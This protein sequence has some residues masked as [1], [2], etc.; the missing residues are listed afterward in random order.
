MV[1]TMA[2]LALHTIS[3]V[4][5]QLRKWIDQVQ[6]GLQSAFCAISVNRYPDLAKPPSDST[7]IVTLINQQVSLGSRTHNCERLRMRTEDP[8]I[9]IILELYLHPLTDQAQVH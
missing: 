7:H 1:L 5:Q 6:I 3:M 9:K 8:R 2:L 4:T